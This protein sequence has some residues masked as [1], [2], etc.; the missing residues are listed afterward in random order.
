MPKFQQS[1]TSTQKVWRIRAKASKFKLSS[2]INI[3]PPPHTKRQ[4]VIST[5]FVLEALKFNRAYFPAFWVS[6]LPLVITL[7][8]HCIFSLYRMA[9]MYGYDC[10]KCMNT[11]L[12]DFALRLLTWPLPGSSWAVVG[13]RVLGSQRGKHSPPSV[14]R[15]HING[16]QVLR[17]DKAR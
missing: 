11:C 12:R 3:N 5:P 6:L 14:L 10:I 13:A 2:W 7:L 16:L 4:N 8:L 17:V 1:P 15:R 9:Q